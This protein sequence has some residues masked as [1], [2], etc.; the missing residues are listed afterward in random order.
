VRFILTL[1][2]LYYCFWHD[3]RFHL[4]LYHITTRFIFQRIIFEFWILV[5][6]KSCNCSCHNES[7][8][9]ALNEL[10]WLRFWKTK[11]D[12]R[13][14][15]FSWSSLSV[16]DQVACVRVSYFKICRFLDYLEGFLFKL[17]VQWT[18]SCYHTLIWKEFS[19]PISDKPMYE[20]R[21]RPKKKG[22]LVAIF[23]SIEN[24]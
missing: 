9:N 1:W 20:L 18:F 6:S 22:R 12:L 19:N 11:A 10:N 8:I 24:R 14:R 21:T 23:P 13:S 3:G 2:W 17:W 16:S 4:Q 5:T 7:I 15:Q